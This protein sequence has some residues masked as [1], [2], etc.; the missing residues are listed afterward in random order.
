MRN[1]S[2]LLILAV[3]AFSACT[4]PFKKAK[5]GTEYKIVSGKGKLLTTGSI[6]EMNNVIKYGDSLLVS[7]YEQGMPAFQP[8]DTAN[9]PPLYKEIFKTVHVGDSIIVRT[10]TDTIL[11]D[12][13]T[14]M[15]APWMKP[16]KFITYVYTIK[17]SYASQEE[18]E[19]ARALLIPKAEAIQ[20]AKKDELAKKDDKVIQDYLAKNNIKATKGPLGTYVEI[21]QPGTGPNID[22]TVV[23]KVNYTGKSL[24][25]IVFD[26]NTQP[27]TDPERRSHLEPLNVNLT[28]DP[29]LG[30][31][32]IPGWNDGLMQLNKGAK[33]RFF[34][35]SGIAYGPQALNAQVGPN[36]ILMFDI[37]VL[38][39]L[40]KAQA[41]IE[42]DATMKKYQDMQK[43]YTDSVAK[44]NA[45]Q[46]APKK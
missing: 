23:V 40:S 6:M 13:Q 20:K 27:S 1:V 36:S 7:S 4:E 18:A 25:G 17:N 39:I 42:S 41:K 21:I 45:A 30:T 15:Q 44:A 8:Y 28:N 26:S 10:S 31:K 29:S 22:T 12:P 2:Y 5:D 35:P 38:D 43:K 11:K 19:K 14:K 16:G 32:V 3:L 46:A 34:I 9:Y 24:A 37:E 33:A